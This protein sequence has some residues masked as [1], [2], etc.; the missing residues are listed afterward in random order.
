MKIEFY[1][2]SLSDSDISN[3]DRVL[4][5]T[6]LT[7]GSVAASFEKKFARYLDLDQVIALSSCTG[8]L[9]LALLALGIGPGDEVITTPMTFIATATAILHT[10]AKPVFVDVEKET[11]LL[12]ISKIDQAITNKTKAVLPVHLYGSM[13]D[14]KKLRSL[15]DITGL[16][17]IEDCAH[18][19][20]GER[21]GIRPGHLGDVAC[22]SFYATKNLTCGEGGCA[23]TNSP[24]LA[25]RIRRLSQHGMSKNAASRY[26]D[27]YQHWDM[28]EYGWKYNLNDIQAALLVDQLDHLDIYWEKREELSSQYNSVLKNIKDVLIPQVYGKSANHLYTI[29]VPTSKRDKILHYLQCKDIGIAVNY[30]SIHTLKYFRENFNFLPN[31]FPNA[32]K[33]GLST[34][35]LPLYP[36]LRHDAPSYIASVLNEAVTTL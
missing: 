26:S 2:H 5:S 22:F 9:H 11:G 33:I 4:K 6:F 24:E 10:G 18:C 31:D 29:W 20:E 7:T 25:A 13:V 14:M 19:I 36:N 30:R 15:C 3:V 21:E 12:D 35:S 17:I 1:K 23:A 34:I 28:I 16:K 32:T 27:K 8:A